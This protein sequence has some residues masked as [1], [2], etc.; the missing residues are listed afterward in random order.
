MSELM[1]VVYVS[2]STRTL[3]ETELEELLFNFR[4]RNKNRGITGLLLYNDLSYMQVIEG[5][6]DVVYALLEKI[7][8]DSRHT[9]LVIL[10]EKPIVDR[11][12]P[13]WS[14]G[15]HIKKS[16][17]LPQTSGFSEF[18]QSN[19]LTSTRNKDSKEVIFLLK[20]FW[21]HT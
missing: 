1:Q 3:S 6:R 11:S 16:S 2:F 15:H 17:Q 20:C 4:I 8:K 12:F 9:N 14:M 19:D 18:M 10:L 21:D 13:N 7:K 5:N